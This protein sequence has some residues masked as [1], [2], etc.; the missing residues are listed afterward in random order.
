MTRV[1]SFTQDDAHIFCSPEQLNAEI[2]GC[3]SLVQLVFSTLGINEFRVRI[4]L[5]DKSSDK[6]I[7]SDA[8]WEASEE[9]LRKSAKDLGISFE[10]KEG[11]AA[12]YG[13]KIDFIV[14]DVIGR[15]WQLGTIQVD[16]NLPERF[17]L[18]Y[19]GADNQKCRPIMI[20]RAPFGSLERFVG[21]LIE[22]F[23][24]DFPTWLAPEQVRLLPLNDSVLGFALDLKHKLAA[25]GIR[26]GIDEH[27]EKLG[28]KIRRA[29][30]NRVP[31]M[32]IVGEKEV[33]AGCVSVRSRINSNFSGTLPIA[34]AE[35]FLKN[36]IDTKALPE[37][38]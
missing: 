18:N 6:Y 17:E 15:E 36:L 30:L 3:L 12:F 1:R 16:Y 32:F 19:V 29:E 34:D 24:G 13:P 4:G 8:S 31:H 35:L 37:K 28:A 26:C 20:H 38:F 10:E 11:E 14:K 27:S 5:R 7:G 22:H 23:S 9:A 25:D 2:N 21:L 33:E